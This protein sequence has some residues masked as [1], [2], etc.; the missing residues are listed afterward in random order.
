MIE[1]KITP[2]ILQEAEER[3]KK[4]HLL[5]GNS[6]THRSDKQRQRMTG[7]LAEV[8]IHN[9]F[10]S[11]KYSENYVVDFIRQNNTF[12]SKAQGCNT[13][14]LNYFSATLYE[15]QKHRNVDYYIFSRVKNDFSIVWICGII[16][17]KKFFRIA[18]LKKSGTKTSNFVYDQSRYEIEYSKLGNIQDF[19][20]WHNNTM[21]T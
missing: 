15:E 16:S 9:I 7:Y 8:S 14:P 19:I 18:D 10:P 12:D 20:K 17:K 13:K 5:F 1:V 21:T 4:Y 11:F 6:G 3:N 2:K